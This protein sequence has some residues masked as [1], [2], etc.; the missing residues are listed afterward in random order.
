V[1]EWFFPTKSP[2]SSAGALTVQVHLRKKC[3]ALNEYPQQDMNE[4][5]K[6][7]ELCEYHYCGVFGK[8][9]SEFPQRET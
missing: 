8:F 2:S 3:P 9:R 6:V 4:E 7:G 1:K 5:Y